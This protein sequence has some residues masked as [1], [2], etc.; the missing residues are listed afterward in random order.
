MRWHKRSRRCTAGTSE[1]LRKTKRLAPTQ[2]NEK[3]NRGE[4]PKVCEKAPV[5]RDSGRGGSVQWVLAEAQLKP[6]RCHNQ[7]GTTYLAP[8]CHETGHETNDA[9][10]PAERQV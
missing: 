5:S 6:L 2:R 7:A 3:G 4:D 9:K 8:Q 10:H 1:N